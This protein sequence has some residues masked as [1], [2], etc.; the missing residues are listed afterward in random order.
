[1]KDEEAKKKI[2]LANMGEKCHLWQGGISFEPYSP[3][4]NNYLK[5]QIRERDNY[6]CQYCHKTHEENGKK[7]MLMIH[8]IDYNK[9]NSNPLNLIA[10]CNSCH[11]KTNGNREFWTRY[12][13]MYQFIRL[14]LFNPIKISKIYDKDCKEYVAY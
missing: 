2:G 1:M 10:L 6:E 9:K 3:K 12:W 4:F 5:E 13:Q 7:L 8:H 14:I 11:S